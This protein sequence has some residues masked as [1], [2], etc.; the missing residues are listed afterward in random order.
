[1]NI[2]HHVIE[3]EA[4][5]I[6]SQSQLDSRYIV[7]T[8]N[9]GKIDMGYIQNSS[10]DGISPYYI[11][12]KNLSNVRILENSLTQEGA[13]RTT[14]S[15]L[16]QI[17]LNGKWNTV[18]INFSLREDSTYGYTFEH[19]PV[20][21]SNFIEIMSGNSSNNLGLNGLPIT[22]GYSTSMGAFPVSPIIDGGSF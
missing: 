21:F 1:M 14:T 2:P 7:K 15:G 22:Q 4:L 12:D 20:G 8:G 6:K 18:V 19:Q 9:L 16:F 10:I 13:V 17:Y 11:T 5:G 3:H